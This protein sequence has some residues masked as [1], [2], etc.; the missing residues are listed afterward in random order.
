[1]T[2]KTFNL[3]CNVTTPNN[4]WGEAS[5]DRFDMD[6]GSPLRST[7]M[8]PGTKIAICIMP[9]DNTCCFDVSKLHVSSNGTNKTFY[10]KLK[11]FL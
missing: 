2:N 8:D 4:S 3:T 6:Y 11:T 5:E 1:M 9:L 10:L 7:D